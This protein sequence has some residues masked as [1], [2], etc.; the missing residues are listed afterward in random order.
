MKYKLFVILNIFSLFSFSQI[1]VDFPCSY[2]VANEIQ[3]GECGVFNTNG[4]GGAVDMNC[5]SVGSSINEGFFWYDGTGSNVLITVT[6][7]VGYDVTVQVL[8]GVDLDPC[9]GF[10]YGDCANEN[11]VNGVETVTGGGVVGSR[12]LIMIENH[13]SNDPITGQVCIVQAPPTCND[14]IQNGFETGIDCGG[15]CGLEECPLPPGYCPTISLCGEPL[16]GIRLTTCNDLGTSKFTSNQT[17][18]IV[19]A[20]S[21][22]NEIPFPNPT[23]GDT[24]DFTYS[25][26]GRVDLNEGV[27]TIITSYENERI[28]STVDADIYCVFYQELD[29]NVLSYVGCDVFAKSTSGFG[30]TVNFSAERLV[31]DSL[32][33]SLH[34]RML[35]YSSEPFS[36]NTKFLGTNENIENDE[37]STS[38]NQ[39]CGC[40][41][42]ATPEDWNG[43]SF[44][45][46]CDGGSWYS[47]ENVTY[48]EFTATDTFVVIAMN[49]V[50]C[51]DDVGVIQFG[52]WENDCNAI[53]NDTSYSNGKFLGC[54]VGNAD[55]QVLTTPGQKYYLV[56]DGNAGSF[57]SWEINYT[58]AL[59]SCYPQVKNISQTYNCGT[60]SV[61][62][63][64]ES[65]INDSVLFV[66]YE[67][68]CNG[69]FVDSSYTGTFTLPFALDKKYGLEV[70]NKSISCNGYS[71]CFDFRISE[72]K[73]IKTSVTT[74]I[75]D[76]I[77]AG[78]RW[79]ENQG[80]YYD[81]LI[82]SLGCDSVVITYASEKYNYYWSGV[83]HIETCE[84]IYDFNGTVV[85]TAGYYFDTISC[86]S[87]HS[88]QIT[89]LSS[90]FSQV[91]ESGCDS[92]FF[93]NQWIYNT[94]IY[95]DT[96][97]NSVGCDSLV[98]WG[99]TIKNSS[100]S[101]IDTT[102]LFTDSILINGNYINNSGTYFDTT[103]NAQNCENIIQYNLNV[104]SSGYTNL[105]NQFNS[106]IKLYPIPFT[107]K[108]IIESI[109]INN[110][111]IY[112]VL[113]KRV[114]IENEFDKKIQ[115]LTENWQGGIYFLRVNSNQV[116][117]LMKEN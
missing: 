21:I 25:A 87:I 12:Y 67:D 70:V 91:F 37:C 30:G 31:F 69:V 96:L 98:K 60:D 95:Y 35:F 48:F 46:M 114:Y 62:L 75:C 89:F 47:N 59:E 84:D 71:N 23:C 117:K 61:F 64:I 39:N 80:I 42:T 14:L 8:E 55:L 68:S 99:I 41:L 107:D 110:L 9:A 66:L 43:P 77:Y 108:L 51:N 50:K 103:L 56:V 73:V 83:G 13:N 19:E 85:D 74:E 100:S 58:N 94:G 72:P 17:E 52:V 33:D 76:S 116:Y 22:I 104:D 15:P 28:V 44:Y 63:S 101:E 45:S 79:Q 53:G 93:K 82:S 57:C 6:P 92:F 27:S 2:D 111:E 54:A 105:F 1:A 109:N 97:Q 32:N 7:D 88:I 90:S 10:F 16:T 4:F 40:N 65:N 3:V 113:G 34:L 38:S 5:D 81:T 11:G 106:D 78:G 102:I 20:D 24:S 36:F 86:D 18:F 112:D 29:C 115:I 26:W 49:N